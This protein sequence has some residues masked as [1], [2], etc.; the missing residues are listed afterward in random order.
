MESQR[1]FSERIHSVQFIILSHRVKKS[2]LVAQEVVALQ[3]VM[4][5]ELGSR[6]KHFQLLI[7]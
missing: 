4:N 1:N 6:F 2:L 5:L 3:M 7:A